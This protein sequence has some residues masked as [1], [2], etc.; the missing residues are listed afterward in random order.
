MRVVPLAYISLVLFV[1]ILVLS[2]GNAPVFGDADTAWHLAAGD[3]SRRDHIIPLSDIW[4]FTAAGEPWYNLSWLFDAGF[5][6]LFAAGGFSALYALTIGVFAGCLTFMVHLCI[7]RGA[8]PLVVF[9][10]IPFA[11]LALYGGVIARPAM[12][13]LIMTILFYH[14]LHC[15]RGTGRLG[16]MLPLPLLMAFWVNLHAGFLLMF[17]IMG[18]FLLE[19]GWEQNRMRIRDYGLIIALCLIATLVN[20]L[21]FAIYYGTIYKVFSTISVSYVTEWKPAEVGHN[22]PMTLFLLLT[23]VIGNSFDRRIPLI[24]RMLAIV[25]LMLSLSSIRYI[26]FAALLLLPT[27]SLRLSYLLYESAIGGRVRELDATITQDMQKSDIRIMGLVMA[28]FAFIFICSP[29]PRDALLESP[30]GFPKKNFPVAE[31]AFIAE[32]YPSLRFL[33]DY[34]LGGYLDYLWRGKVKVFIDGRASSLYSEE[35]LKDYFNFMDSAGFG[36]RAEITAA[37]YHLDGLII[38]NDAKNANLWAWNPLWKAVYHGK[39]ATVYIRKELENKK[40]HTI[41]RET[42]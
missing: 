37:Y 38:P 13:S 29:T 7:K 39:V 23:L 24:D 32:H 19:A 26:I 14:I 9:L 6:A 4:S 28:A 11:L 35:L 25:M 21:G 42:F 10:L 8:S 40:Q 30:V 41:R 3:L 5:S 18:L 27:L 16:N 34:N 15:Y 2:F 12:C 36:G 17:L 33:N 31:A 22:L 20:P 1:L